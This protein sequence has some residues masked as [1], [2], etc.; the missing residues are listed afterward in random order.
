MSWSELERLVATAEADG[1][2][3]QAL[4]RCRSQA[5]LVLAARHLGYRITRHDL[6]AALAEHRREQLQG[7][8]VGG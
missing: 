3:R 8:G 6:A 2:L 4:K 7:Q 5:E 1:A